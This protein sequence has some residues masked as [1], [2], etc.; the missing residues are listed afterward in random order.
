M[1]AL[2][3]KLDFLRIGFTVRAFFQILCVHDLKDF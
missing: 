2:F 3:F 1:L